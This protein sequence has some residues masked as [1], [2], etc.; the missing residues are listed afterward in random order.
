MNY[1]DCQ[2][3][4]FQQTLR[5]HAS[6]QFCLTIY[7]YWQNNLRLSRRLRRKAMK[8]M[9]IQ[10][11]MILLWQ[12]AYAPDT[13]YNN[14][15]WFWKFYSREFFFSCLHESNFSKQIGIVVLS[16]WDK[17][18]GFYCS[19]NLARGS[20]S[21]AVFQGKNNTLMNEFFNLARCAISLK[22][23]EFHPQEMQFNEL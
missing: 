10:W 4:N 7:D 14:S 1:D 17:S 2:R 9:K 11:K 8:A 16:D 23:W 22:L 5:S 3:K 12:F 21:L 19:K 6:Y 18:S 15:K 20:K 13:K